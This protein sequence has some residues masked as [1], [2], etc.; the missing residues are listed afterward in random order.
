LNRQDAQTTPG[1][2]SK[3][4]WVL[5]TTEALDRLLP[6]FRFESLIGA[7]GMGAVYRAVQRSMERTVAI[8]VLPTA[9]FAEHEGNFAARFKQEALTM[10]R[11]RM[12]FLVYSLWVRVAGSLGLHIHALHPQGAFLAPPGEGTR[13]SVR[14]C[15][16]GRTP[17]P[18]SSE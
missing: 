7:G 11:L 15:P 14:D 9:L 4:K 16:T 18:R 2:G 13:P 17:S 5:P 3:G 6:Q 1:E 10:A 12:D 8:K